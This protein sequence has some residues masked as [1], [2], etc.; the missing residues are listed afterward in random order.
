MIIFVDMDETICHRKE[1][2]KK[3]YE[4]SDPYPERIEKINKLYDEGHTIMYWTARGARSGINWFTVTYKQLQDWGCK[5]HELSFKGHNA[6]Y[7]I[8]DRGI[9]AKEF[10]DEN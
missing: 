9:N 4:K 3:D 10:F 1:E 6:N 2:Y 7:F 5:Y 8:D